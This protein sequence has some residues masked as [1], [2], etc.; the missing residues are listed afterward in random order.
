[1][2]C[3]LGDRNDL[4]YAVVAAWLVASVA[5]SGWMW[6]SKLTPAVVVR[7]PPEAWPAAS[8]TW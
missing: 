8:T 6:R 1:M 7:E 3:R 5:A 4:L 2:P